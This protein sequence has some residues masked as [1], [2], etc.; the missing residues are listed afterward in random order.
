[1][2]KVLDAHAL[3]IYLRNEPGYDLVQK[4][5]DKASERGVNL[6]M[7]RMNWGEVYYILNRKHGKAQAKE[8]IDLIDMLPIDFISVDDDQVKAAA[9]IKSQNS[10]SYADCF[11]AALAK[12]YKAKLLTGDPE[13]KVLEKEIKIQWIK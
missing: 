10:L 13:F 5:F 1:M 12:M 2:Q 3:L 8:V 9:E 11:A 6:V 7:S 4:A